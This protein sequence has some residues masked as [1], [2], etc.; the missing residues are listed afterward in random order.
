MEDITSTKL[1]ATGGH[2][3]RHFEQTTIRRRRGDS[4]GAVTD[5][6]RGD[7]GG[8]LGETSSTGRGDDKAIL[9]QSAPRTRK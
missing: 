3:G 8:L 6:G 9:Q 7:Q 1:A 4:G 2:R 5:E